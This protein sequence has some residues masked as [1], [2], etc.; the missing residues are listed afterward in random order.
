MVWSVEVVAYLKCL[1]TVRI[2]GFEESERNINRNNLVLS[3]LEQDT[4]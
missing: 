2:K 3:G 4:S 1:A